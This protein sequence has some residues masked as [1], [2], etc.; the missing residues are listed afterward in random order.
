[1][2]GVSAADP[3]QC[4]DIAADPL[5]E[6][7]SQVIQGVGGRR[8]IVAHRCGKGHRVERLGDHADGAERAKPV[9][10]AALGARRHEDDRNPGRSGIFPQPASVAGPSMT[11]I[12][13]SSRMMSGFQS[14][15]P[16]GF[17]TRFAAPY[18][19][20]RIETE[21]YPDDFADIRLVVDVEKASPGHATSYAARAGNSARRS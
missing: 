14:R 8:Q 19:E 3:R 7:G 12:M 17:G 6:T 11:G 18:L 15:Q 16:S 4:P 13:T 2:P 21:R 9:D 10:L 5:Q 1:M 20:S